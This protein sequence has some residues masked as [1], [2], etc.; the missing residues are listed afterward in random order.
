M[1]YCNLVSHN[2]NIAVYK[3]GSVISDITGVMRLDCKDGSYYIAQKPQREEIYEL[4]VKKMLRKYQ[5]Q[6]RNGII[7]EKM[8]YEI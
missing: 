7:P 3:I 2:D 4:F 1:V 6:F 5:S 8:S